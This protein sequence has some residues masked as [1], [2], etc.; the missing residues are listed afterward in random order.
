MSKNVTIHLLYFASLG[1]QLGV[2]EEK[3][4]LPTEPCTLEKL[5]A[6]LAQRGEAWK[7]K[8]EDN[9]TLCA[10]NQTLCNDNPEIHPGDEVAF[11]P[12]VTGG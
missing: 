4:D 10:V 3:I 2:S 6:Y 7:I 5:K 9:T 1:E 8:L 11:F 12:P